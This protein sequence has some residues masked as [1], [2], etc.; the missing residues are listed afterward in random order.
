MK[1][2]DLIKMKVEDVELFLENN[3]DHIAGN[4][5][6]RALQR[7]IKTEKKL[8]RYG[9]RHASRTDGFTKAYRKGR[10]PSKRDLK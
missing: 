1:Y 3:P 8:K 6:L 4:N 9:K 2:A 10:C 7:E 5:A